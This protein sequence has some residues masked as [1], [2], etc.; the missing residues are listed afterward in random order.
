MQVAGPASHRDRKGSHTELD[1]AAFDIKLRL[2]DL[3]GRWF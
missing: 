3:L 2:L 1:V